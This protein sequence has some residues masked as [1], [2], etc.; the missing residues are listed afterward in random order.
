MSTYT[1]HNLL[2]GGN[3]TDNKTP[4]LFLSFS[5]CICL[6]ILLSIGVYMLTRP[7]AKCSTLTQC[8][9]NK[10]KDSSKDKEDCE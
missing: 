10:V 2:G 4:F 3:T 9:G 7:N 5:T 6:L 8:A 1:I